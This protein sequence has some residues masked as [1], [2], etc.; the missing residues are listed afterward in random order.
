MHTREDLAR[1]RVFLGEKTFFP[2]PSGA[3]DQIGCQDAG[4][5]EGTRVQLSNRALT[6][7]TII[8]NRN[9]NFRGNFTHTGYWKGVA[10]CGP[11]RSATP[12]PSSEHCARTDGIINPQRLVTPPDTVCGLYHPARRHYI[13]LCYFHS[14]N[15][16]DPRVF[17]S[18]A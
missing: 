16:R 18:D 4:S 7:E 5:R 13:N 6:R 14:P 1:F 11:A 9:I 8:P 3:I 17:D 10:A 15:C 12:Y 2:Y